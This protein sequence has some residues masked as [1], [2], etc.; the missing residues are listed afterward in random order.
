MEVRS[1]KVT[2]RDMEGVA[3]TVNVTAGSLNEAVALGL[4]ALRGDDWV[5]GIAQ[6]LNNVSVAVQNVPVEHKVPLK[7][8]NH[9]IEQNGGSPKETLRRKR[10]REILGMTS[11]A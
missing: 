8:F 3:H 11:G 7:E 6:G 4:K 1:C 2:I 5:E 10:I 9:W